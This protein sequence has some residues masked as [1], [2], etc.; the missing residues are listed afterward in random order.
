[1][2]YAGFGWVGGWLCLCRCWST[3]QLP[4]GFS[5]QDPA[6]LS[7]LEHRSLTQQ[8]D[9]LTPLPLLGGIRVNNWSLLN[10]LRLS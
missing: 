8:H 5:V 2:L 6:L 7:A 4:G 3:G 1:M 10:Q 9:P